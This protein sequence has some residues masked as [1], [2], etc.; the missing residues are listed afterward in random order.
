M[1]ASP[2]R[3][4]AEKSTCQSAPLVR[5]LMCI[6]WGRL[7]HSLGGTAW[8]VVSMLAFDAPIELRELI[9][10]IGMGTSYQSSELLRP[11]RAILS[12]LNSGGG[13]SSL[14]TLVGRP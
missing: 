14:N 5:R 13:C 1:S 7:S 10:L 2:E 8:S 12:Q 3:I 9:L 11:E 4:Q 6:T